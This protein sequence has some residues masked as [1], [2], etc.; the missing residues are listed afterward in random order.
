MHSEIH[1]CIKMGTHLTIGKKCE[2][3]PW[4]TR[5]GPHSNAGHVWERWGEKILYIT[6]SCGPKRSQ[7]VDKPGDRTL[8]IIQC[9]SNFQNDPEARCLLTWISAKTHHKMMHP[10]GPSCSYWSKKPSRQNI[11][12]KEKD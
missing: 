8:I 9:S 10:S 2:G 3:K 11:S 4:E 5:K 6:K 1:R 12:G 7:W